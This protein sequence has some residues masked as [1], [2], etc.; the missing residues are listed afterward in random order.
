VPTGART[1]SIVVTTAGGT[2]TS[3]RSFRVTKH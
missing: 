1:G 2:A 3:S